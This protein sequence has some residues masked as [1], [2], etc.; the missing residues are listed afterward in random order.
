M[1]TAG[2]REGFLEEMPSKE[3]QKERRKSR[4]KRKGK[5]AFLAGGE[6]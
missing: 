2:I 1:S 4:R 3:Y 5:R 6:A